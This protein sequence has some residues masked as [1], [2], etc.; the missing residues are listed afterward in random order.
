MKKLSGCLL[1][2][3]SLLFVTNWVQPVNAATAKAATAQAVAV[4]VDINVASAKELQTLPGIGQVTA[5]RIIDYR[6]AKGPFS[7]MEDL[8]KVKGIGQSTL[9]KFS[10][11]IVLK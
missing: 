5:Q 8:L 3:L 6:S 7:A 1:I 4:K 9:K 11:R 10:G 2:V